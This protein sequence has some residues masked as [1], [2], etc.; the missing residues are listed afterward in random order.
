MNFNLKPG[1]LK[2]VR[3]IGWWL[4][5][6]NLAQISINLINYKISNM[7]SAFE[8]CKRDADEL[9]IGLC[10]SQIVGLVP[11]AAMLDVANYYIEKEKLLVFEED[12]KIKLVIQRLGLNSLSQFNPR[13]RIIE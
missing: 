1:R 9:N 11:L 12:Q 3:A 4:E 2:A 10:G 5:E 13:D 6:A 8:E 7:H